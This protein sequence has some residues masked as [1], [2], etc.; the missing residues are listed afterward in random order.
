M[1]VRRLD[2]VGSISTFLTNFR[3]ANSYTVSLS[4]LLGV[5]LL[6][7]VRATTNKDVVKVQRPCS[8]QTVCTTNGCYSLIVC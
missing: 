6:R 8:E 4:E 7:N 3:S 1:A 2:V 5:Y